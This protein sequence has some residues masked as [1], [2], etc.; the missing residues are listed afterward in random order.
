MVCMPFMLVPVDARK[1]VL[2]L[3]ELDFKAIVSCLIL[4]LRPK[5]Q[6]SV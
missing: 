1:K 5:L 6:P 2:D 3:L 4:V